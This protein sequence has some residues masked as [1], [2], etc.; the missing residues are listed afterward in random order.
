MKYRRKMYKKNPIYVNL[1]GQQ[2]FNRFTMEFFVKMDPE[3]EKIILASLSQ[4]TVEDSD[5][6]A[7]YKEFLDMFCYPYVT[8]GM[9]DAVRNELDMKPE[10]ED[11]GCTPPALH[12]VKAIDIWKL[13]NTYWGPT[14]TETKILKYLSHATFMLKVGVN[15]QDYFPNV[16]AVDC[17]EDK[18]E[19]LYEFTKYHRTVDDIVPDAEMCKKSSVT[20]FKEYLQAESEKIFQERNAKKKRKKEKP[21][22]AEPFGFWILKCVFLS[23][24]Y[25]SRPWWLGFYWAHKFRK[26]NREVFEDII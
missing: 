15:V 16:A 25:I 11:G 17:F 6:Y 8:V 24:R 5:S 14:A 12:E 20:E 23:D 3:M 21:F 26:D 1:D 7:V 19:A 18:F 13:Y 10:S 9:Y 2:I 4:F 22:R